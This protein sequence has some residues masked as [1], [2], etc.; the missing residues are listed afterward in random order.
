MMYGMPMGNKHDI[1]ALTSDFFSA[2]SF[3]EGNKPAYQNL[4]TLF[5]ESGQLIKIVQACPKYPR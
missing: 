3:T 1:D 4:Y 5:I 2:V